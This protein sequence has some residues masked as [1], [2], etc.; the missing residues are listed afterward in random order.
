MA[1]TDASTDVSAPTRATA[2]DVGVLILRVGIGAAMLQAGLIKAFDFSTTVGF[3]E[4]GGWRLPTLAALMVTTA[5]TLGGIGLLLG[6]LTPVTAFAVIAAMIDAWAVNVSTA[7]FW[8]AAPGRR[9][10]R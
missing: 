3:M 10:W 6:A 7:A 2:T 1:T 9:G 5:E 8:V 4:A